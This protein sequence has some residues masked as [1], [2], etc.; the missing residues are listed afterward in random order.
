MLPL[1]SDIFIRGAYNKNHCD[2]SLAVCNSV[3]VVAR[4]LN[5]ETKG[6]RGKTMWTTVLLAGCL[7]LGQV[8]E[9]K[10]D[11][12]KLEQSVRRLVRQLD[13]ETLAE[14]EDAEKAL[15]ELGPKV[16]P[17]LPPSNDNQPA[18]MK[19]RLTRIRLKL[20]RDE[21]E[22]FTKASLIT[23][24]GEELSLADIAAAI[25]KQTGNP[26][27]DY[28]E[29]FGEEG[30]N[31]KLKIA[32]E[33]TPFWQAV[34]QVFDQANLA[35]YAYAEERGVAFQNRPEG[36]LPAVG[37]VAYAGPF[38]VEATELELIRN[39]RQKESGALQLGLEFAW[40]PRLRPIALFQDLDKIEIT[41]EN[42]GP[43]AID[44]EQAE[45][46]IGIIPGENTA[47]IMLPL[48]LP[49]RSVQKIASLKCKFQAMLPGKIEKYQF[50]GLTPGKSMEQKKG[51]VT[52]KL[53]QIRKNNV[54]WEIRVLVT[55]DESSGALESHRRWITDNPCFL[56]RGE[57]E[58]LGYA[59]LELYRRDENSVGVAY[60]FDIEGELKDYSLFYETP[61]LILKSSLEYELKNLTLP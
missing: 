57:Q 26:I 39:L 10:S 47:T 43:L 16:L 3:V 22:S 46:E 60:L 23:L 59:A 17:L 11:D 18:E 2:L 8:T 7:T 20:Q 4:P 61:V 51:G 49:P 55:L 28:R 58:P 6:K 12:G 21:A 27:L 24:K 45:Q 9:G 50:A 35:R 44:L 36:L 31:P 37:R 56:Q 30:T 14:R 19:V 13:G 48:A 42:G 29:R 52:V 53:E 15:I 38:R 34:D 40:E 54:V 41:D 25:G 1:P 5:R 33:N 32:F